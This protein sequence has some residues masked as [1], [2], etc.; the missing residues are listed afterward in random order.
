MTD[1]FVSRVSANESTNEKPRSAWHKWLYWLLVIVAFL[2][3]VGLLGLWLVQYPDAVLG[4]SDV[5]QQHFWP[6]AMTRWLAYTV[7][8]MFCWPRIA[9]WCGRLDDTVNAELTTAVMSW[10]WPLLRIVV[11]YE[12]LF[13]FNIFSFV[14]GYL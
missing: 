12:L 8:L 7:F 6:L 14:G 10:R 5:V 13:P 2:L 1:N 3:V 9:A 11:V 4:M